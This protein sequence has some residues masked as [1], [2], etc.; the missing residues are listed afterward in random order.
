MN[1]DGFRFQI[2]A[3]SI[4]DSM[5][6]YWRLLAGLINK[7]LGITNNQHLAPEER[8]NRIRARQFVRGLP[9]SVRAELD[10]D[11]EVQAVLKDVAERREAPSGETNAACV[12]MAVLQATVTA[13][14]SVIG[15]QQAVCT[16][17]KRYIDNDETC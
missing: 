12:E 9:P 1:A 15:T 5:N 6:A 14:Q 8:L 4:G 13:S 7:G 16:R 17:A 11:P 2:A 3:F 10:A